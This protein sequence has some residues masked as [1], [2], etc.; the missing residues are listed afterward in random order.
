MP[1]NGEFKRLEAEKRIA[2]ERIQS[3]K[4]IE[5]K[6]GRTN[7]ITRINSIISM[8]TGY[9]SSMISADLQD[10]S[11]DLDALIRRAVGARRTLIS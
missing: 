7:Y 3:Q 2:E 10:R 9:A 4:G 8:G 11:I 1:K 6:Q 5:G